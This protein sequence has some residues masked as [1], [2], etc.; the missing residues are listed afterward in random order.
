M[1]WDFNSLGGRWPVQMCPKCLVPPDIWGFALDGALQ[2]KCLTISWFI[3]PINFHELVPF[4][5]T[6]NH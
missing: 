2:V 5:S 4:I 6:I 1:S 3:D